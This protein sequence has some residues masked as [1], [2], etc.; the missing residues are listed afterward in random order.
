MKTYSKLNGGTGNQILFG[1]DAESMLLTFMQTTPADLAITS[2]P[3]AG[4]Q[5]QQ[6]WNSPCLHRTHYWLGIRIQ[7]WENKTSNIEQCMG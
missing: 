1:I 5:E 3:P 2:G 6:S 7:T 4:S